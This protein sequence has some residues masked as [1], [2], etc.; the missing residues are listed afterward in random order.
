MTVQYRQTV[1]GTEVLKPKCIRQYNLA[2][3]GVDLKDKMVEP[4][5]LERKQAKKSYIKFFF[6]LLNVAVH[7]AVMVYNS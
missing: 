3:G 1:R 4:F 7:N 2:K 5:V 6:R